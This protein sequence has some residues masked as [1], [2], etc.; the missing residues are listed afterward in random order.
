[1]E[2]PQG[3][4]PV[5]LAFTVAGATEA[6]RLSDGFG[7]VVSGEDGSNPAMPREAKR[8]RWLPGRMIQI[9]PPQPM[10][11][12]AQ[13]TANLTNIYRQCQHAPPAVLPLSASATQ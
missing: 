13:E 7:A 10:R 3:P 11:Y 1:M 9:P 5:A 8:A 4:E 6:T 2:R 12:G